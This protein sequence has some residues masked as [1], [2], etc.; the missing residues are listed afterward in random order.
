MTACASIVSIWC[1]G[2]ICP[3]KIIGSIFS[4][5]VVLF[6]ATASGPFTKTVTRYGSVS[7]RK[8]FVT[9][10]CFLPFIFIFHARFTLIY[11]NHPCFI[12]KFDI[13]PFFLSLTS[14]NIH[15]IM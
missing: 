1:S 5:S 6:T 4:I 9:H 15:Y 8:I 12:S 14:K 10:D 11:E 7:N 3:L 2:E 13:F